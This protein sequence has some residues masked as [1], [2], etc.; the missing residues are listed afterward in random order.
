MPELFEIMLNSIAPIFIVVGLAAML[1][2]RFNPDPK[3][4]STIILYLFS[5]FLVFN[6]LAQREFSGGE[7]LQLGITAVTV[8]LTMAGIGLTL[9]RLLKLDE[10]TASAFVLTLVMT[11]T[12]N[13]G[14]PLNRFAFGDT[15][16]LEQIAEQRAL[17]YHVAM[18]MVANTLGIYLA[19]RGSFSTRQAVGNIFR[20]PL[21]Y[22]AILGLAFGLLDI[23]LP[24]FIGRP[25]ELLAGAAIPAMLVLLG[26][27]LSTAVVRGR[28][29]LILLASSARLM[30]APLIAFVVVSLLG[31]SDMPFNVAIV[32]AS[33]PTAV[34]A[35]V[36]AVQ[37]GADS[38]FVT[39]TIITGTLMSILTL[40]VL[41]S[42]LT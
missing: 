2:R 34:M 8:S 30:I 40:S 19:S 15:L 23:D 36:L 17:L 10:R 3:S 12:G 21:I 24:L 25:V 16:E 5:P 20:V 1:S 38:E 7:A 35:S 26:I 6:G 39:S 31:L 9:A 28:I 13:Y 14:L 32:Q 18:V 33:M 37:F 22:G 4:L 42:I 29:S 27:Q 41:L 11:N